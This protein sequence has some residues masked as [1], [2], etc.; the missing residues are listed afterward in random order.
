MKDHAIQT[1]AE[2]SSFF[3]PPEWVKAALVLA[4]F[5]TWV[6]IGLFAYLN[7]Y[8]KKQYFRMWTVAWMFYAVW[9]AASIGLEESPHAP[10][11]VMARRACIGISALFMF[12]G[13]FQLTGHQRDLRELGMGIAM[14]MIWSYVAAYKVQDQLWITVPVFALLASASVYTGLLYG[15][16]RS[17]YRGANLLAKGFVLWGIHLLANAFQ[18]IASP[19]YMTAAYVAAAIIALF[20]A[21]GMMVQVLEQARERNESLLVEFKKGQAKR[22]LLQEEITVSEQKYRTLF[23]A[24]SDAIFLVDLETLK[25]VEANE[26]A[27]SLTQ[28][29]AVKLL[30]ASF[31]DLCP[32]ISHMPSALLDKKRM[33]DAVFR[34]SSEFHI[35]RPNGAHVICEGS[36]NLV[37]WQKRPVLQLSIREIAERKKLEQ[38]VRQSEKLTA[39]GQL[40]AGVAHELNNPL[41]VIMGY[42]QILA[43]KGGVD[44]RTKSDTLKILHESER[45]AKIVRNLLT[46]ARPTEPQMV[47]VDINR[48]A[49][50]VLDTHD[51]ELKAAGIE[52]KKHLALNLPRTKADPNQIEQVL[53][54]L[55]VNANHAMAG[56]TG[57]RILQFTTQKVGDTIQITVS[58]TG[59]GI[60]PNIVDKIFDPF[61]TT[62]PP[63]KGTGLGLSISYSIIEEH[64]GK[65]SVQSEPGKGAKFTVELPVVSCEADTEY[66]VQSSTSAT[67]HDPRAASKRLLIVDD[68]PGIVDMLSIV[69]GD[70]GYSIDTASDGTE[71]IQRVLSGSYDVIISDLCMPGMGGEQL[72][73]AVR[74]QD[75]ELANR[76]IFVTGDTVSPKSRSFLES[77]GNRWLSKPFSIADIEEVVGGVL[78]REPAAASAGNGHGPD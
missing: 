51:K 48:L 32:N 13:S 9:L 10:F 8:T 43:K 20:I 70:V 63:G 33:F 27:Q 68:E 37:Q 41:A 78:Q 1:L 56:Q 11:L 6:V 38:Q 55:V 65:L 73:G 23:D 67:H 40:I 50:Y 12:W 18:G 59:A 69:L 35:V 36:C 52:V 22:R 15:R 60:P 74:E 45:A 21:M 44:E 76:I 5:S 77:T 42:A 46:F 24:A 53:T 39:L 34:P 14:I 30:G 7:R 71:A 3:F 4:F 66:R 26:S 61:F 62:K 72:H 57:P 17:R 29:P 2:A 54:N 47:V 19:G 49:S 16:Y 25:V 75:P 58:D 28:R 64:G 31:V